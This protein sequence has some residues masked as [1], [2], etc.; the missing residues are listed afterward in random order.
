MPVTEN[1]LSRV[2]VVTARD[3]NDDLT[4]ILN[5]ESLDE[6]DLAAERIAG[7]VRDLLMECIFPQ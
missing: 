4:I 2:A 6:I 7:K 1:R 3:I 5:S